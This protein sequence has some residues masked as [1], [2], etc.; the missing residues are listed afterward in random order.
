MGNIAPSS[1]KMFNKQ[2]LLRSPCVDVRYH[3]VSY[4]EEGGGTNNTA[5]D[6]T[7]FAVRIT[8]TGDHEQL[9]L[10]GERFRPAFAERDNKQTIID[11]RGNST[12]WFKN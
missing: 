9:I 2:S 3:S 10:N 7:V 5:R 11:L 1:V 4:E 6:Q 12:N 8:E